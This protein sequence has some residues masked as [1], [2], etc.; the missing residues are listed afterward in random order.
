MR[1][2]ELGDAEQAVG[3]AR[4][5]EPL[6]GVGLVRVWGLGVRVRIRVRVRVRVAFRVR[7]RVRFRTRVRAGVRARVGGLGVGLER[8]YT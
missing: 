5:A 3:E 7:V 6:L 8:A 1:D 4:G 2:E